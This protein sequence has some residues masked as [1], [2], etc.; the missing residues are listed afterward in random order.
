MNNVA[1]T[2]TWGLSMSYNQFL[3]LN[4]KSLYEIEIV[5]KK[6]KS[7]LQIGELFIKGG[8]KTRNFN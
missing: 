2:N 6:Y 1:H 7:D 4:K 5:S 8:I 3:K